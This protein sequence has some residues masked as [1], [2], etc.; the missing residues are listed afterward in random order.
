MK[1]LILADN[2][3]DDLLLFGPLYHRLLFTGAPVTAKVANDLADLVLK[4][5]AK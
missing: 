2:G 3:F 4:A 5:I 1:A